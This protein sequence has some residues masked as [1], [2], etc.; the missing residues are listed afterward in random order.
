MVTSPAPARNAQRPLRAAAPDFPDEPATNNTCPN[1][2]LCPSAPR[3][4][5]R[6]TNSSTPS[7][8]SAPSPN[9]SMRSGG[10]PIRT[11]S[12]DPQ[13]SAWSE[14]NWPT[15]GAVKVTVRWANRTEPAGASPSEGKPEGVSTERIRAGR[16]NVALCDSR[17][18]SEMA[19]AM[20]P[21]TGPR[22]PGPNNATTRTV[23]EPSSGNTR[24][25]SSSVT[26]DSILFPAS[27]QRARFAAASPSTPSGL[28]IQ[29]TRGNRV[30]SFKYRAATNPSPPLL[31]LPHNTQ[32]RTL[33]RP[34]TT[35][36]TAS[37]TLR[38]AAS[39]NCRLGMPYRS[40]VRRSTSRLSG[41][42]VAFQGGDRR[43]HNNQ[44]P[45]TFTTCP[46]PY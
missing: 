25:Q 7:Q 34:A 24:S 40:V 27:R 38:P 37:A 32:T 29:R 21:V 5:A 31:P 30:A 43:D 39:I 10:E 1:C 11:T 22:R 33:S 12:R 15:F 16:G 44:P 3:T 35:R 42:V 9:A 13:A 36:Q 20:T 8:R 28:P 2:P 41:A 26:I 46:V 4:S 18:M 23:A 6:D 14:I 19:R 17:L 45:P